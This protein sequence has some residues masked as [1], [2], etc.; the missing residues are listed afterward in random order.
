MLIKF[1]FKKVIKCLL[2]FFFSESIIK[3]RPNFNEKFNYFFFIIKNVLLIYFF[4]FK[5]SK[6]KIA[7]TYDLYVSPATIG[8]FLFNYFF[9]R[10]FSLMNYEVHFVI[11][12]KE[13]RN[14]WGLDEKQKK[15]YIKTI[16]NI[17]NKLSS[18]NDNLKILLFDWDTFNNR[19]L[20]SRL[21]FIPLKDDVVTRSR[22]YVK[23][24]NLLNY[25]LFFKS[26]N[27][28]NK[29]LLDKNRFLSNK[30]TNQY[31]TWHCRNDII[32]GFER[33]IN[34]EDFIN[35]YHT[36]K[37]YYNQYEILIVSDSNGC[38]LI[39]DWNNT[40]KFNLKYSK[41]FSTDFLGDVNLVL[42]SNFYFQYRGGGM[43]AIILFTKIPYLQVS[44]LGRLRLFSKH[45]ITSWALNKQQFFHLEKGN[46]PFSNSWFIQYN[47]F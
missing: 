41:D 10:F 21:Y 20:K 43:G 3:K 44:F 9:A 23:T 28:K 6:K 38:E 2:I 13:Y 15:L 18:D 1:S 4:I 14:D 40:L 47:K 35:I 5:N 8:D 16:L 34:K 33:N 39:K 17:A 22:I 45:R 37:K 12:N 19:Y 30:L 11:I 31:I 24:F 46:I 27:F 7:I 42:N 25:L 26:R 36:L 32:S 29:F